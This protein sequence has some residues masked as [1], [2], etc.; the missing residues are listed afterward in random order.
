MTI[1]KICVLGNKDKKYREKDTFEEGCDVPG[2]DPSLLHELSQ[3]NLQEEDWDTPDES[4]QQVGDQE[5]SC[6]THIPHMVTIV[7][8]QVETLVLGIFN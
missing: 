3:C 7:T 2:R 4:D 6:S 5:N 1:R 8:R